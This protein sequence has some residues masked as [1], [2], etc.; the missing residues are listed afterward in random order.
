VNALPVVPDFDVLE[1]PLYRLLTRFELFQINEFTLDD[2]VKRLDTRIIK[3]V[4]L[5]THAPDHFVFLH[6]VLIVVRGVLAPA[7]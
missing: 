2:A 3:A 7:V 5:S 4:A 6:L 1:N